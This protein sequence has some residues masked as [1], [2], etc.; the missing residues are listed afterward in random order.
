MV[1]LIQLVQFGTEWVLGHPFPIIFAILKFC[2]HYFLKI[3]RYE[4]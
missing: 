4:I 1:S 3:A 2:V